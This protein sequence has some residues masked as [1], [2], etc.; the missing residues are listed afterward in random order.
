MGEGGATSAVY[1]V[2]VHRPVAGHREELLQALTAPQSAGGKVQTGDLLF[3]HLEGADWTFLTVTR[4]N[5][6]QDFAT[7]RSGA[8]AASGP[9]SWGGAGDRLCPWDSE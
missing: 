3:Q 5:S 7:D 6:W 2:G 8:A 9:G 4:H 1:T